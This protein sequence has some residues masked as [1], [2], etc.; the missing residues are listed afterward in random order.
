M[1]LKFIRDET[2]LIKIMRYLLLSCWFVFLGI[3]VNAQTTDIL[4]YLPDS[5]EM[6][7]YDYTSKQKSNTKFYFILRSTGKDTFSVS[8]CQYYE[9]DKKF[10]ER[11]VFITKR[12]VV[13]NK[14]IYPL[15]FDYDYIF[16]TNDTSR[17]GVYGN[18]ANKL[19]RLLPIVHCFNVKFT[20]YYI[21]DNANKPIGYAN[22]Q[23]KVE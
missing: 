23:Y 22:K 18:R 4:Y 15:L 12:K 2:N 6:K 7:V 19:A 21:L 20:K 1:H 17:V 13:I 10:L 11:W 8:V 9:K 3:H 14:D 16:S 5:V